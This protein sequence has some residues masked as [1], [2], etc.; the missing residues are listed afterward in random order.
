MIR[1]LTQR[2]RTAAAIAKRR[3]AIRVLHSWLVQRYGGLGIADIVRVAGQEGIST[4]WEEVWDV[5]HGTPRERLV[6]TGASR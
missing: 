2:R 4:T 3:E 6:V 5:I 1:L